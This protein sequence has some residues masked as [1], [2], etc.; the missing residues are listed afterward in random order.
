MGF[1]FRSLIVG[2]HQ[3]Y[4]IPFSDISPNHLILEPDSTVMDLLTSDIL[5]AQSYLGIEATPARVS[6]QPPCFED[7]PWNDLKCRQ[8]PQSYHFSQ[9]YCRWQGLIFEQFA[10]SSQL[11]RLK[12]CT[13][14]IPILAVALDGTGFYGQHQRSWQTGLGNIYISSY[15]PISWIKTK[16]DI[17][18]NT[19]QFWQLLQI[20]PCMAVIKALEETLIFKPDTDVLIK[21]PNDIVVKKK[22]RIFKLAGCLTEVTMQQ[23]QIVSIRPGIGLNVDHAPFL[24]SDTGYSAICCKDICINDTPDLYTRLLQSIAQNLITIDQKMLEPALF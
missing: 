5:T 23:Q 12:Y 18:E 21:R 22:G 14:S 8:S 10:G 19:L 3:R 6:S 15:I 13:G 4:R 9:D 1:S 24:S 16:Y 2:M 20:L 17:P 7:Y 11:E